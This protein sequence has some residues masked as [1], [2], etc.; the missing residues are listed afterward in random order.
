MIKVKTSCNKCIH[1]KTCRDVENMKKKE[2][3]RATNAINL[4]A[5]RRIE[6]SCPRYKKSYL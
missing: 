5:L 6:I 2:M 1:K 3:N 4:D